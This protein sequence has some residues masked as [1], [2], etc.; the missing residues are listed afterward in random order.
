MT[1]EQREYRKERPLA[2]IIPPDRRRAHAA[3]LVLGGMAAGAALLAFVQRATERASAPEPRNA[4]G[5]S[6]T[7]IEAFSV[8]AA[9]ADITSRRPG[10][11]A[12]D[13][14]P[15]QSFDLVVEGEVW[16]ILVASVDSAGRPYGTHRWGT[17]DYDPTAVAANYDLLAIPKTAWQLAVL[18]N[19]APRNDEKGGLRHLGGGVH[20]LRLYASDSGAFQP[21]SYF[22]A[23]IIGPSGLR[24]SEPLAFHG[25]GPPQETSS[26]FNR[27][28]ASSALS[29]V[30]LRRCES[31]PGL[32]GSGHVTVQFAPDG[33]ITQAEVDQGGNEKTPRGACIAR[34]F[35]AA[36]IP[37]FSGAPVRVGKSFTIVIRTQGDP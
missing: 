16:S 20:H 10:P 24:S 14:L 35:K 18:E 1:D 34:L 3:A 26:P 21:G 22:R 17:N 19:A 32:D 29:N 33:T 2:E 12:S 27:G 36:R 15:D 31:E 9:T 13:S 4:Q 30:D 28:A 25:H 37:A 7:S 23:Y 6:A 5:L 11:I 8:G